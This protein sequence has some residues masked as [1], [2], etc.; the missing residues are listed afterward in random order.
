M[1]SNGSLRRELGPLVLIMLLSLWVYANAT[2]TIFHYDDIP[3]ILENPYLGSR[4]GFVDLLRTGRPLRAISF[5]IDYQVWTLDS[6]GYHFTNNLLHGFCALVAFFLVRK[7]YQDRRL[8]LLAALIFALHPVNTE[9]V[10]GVSHRKEL[11]CFLFMGLSFL[12]FGRTGKRNF[13]FGLSLL[14]YLLAL[15]SKQVALAL[16][17]LLLLSRSLFPSAVP[18]KRG[19]FWIE[20]GFFIAI[21]VLAFVFTLSDFKL[22]ARFQPADFA[23]HRYLEILATQLGA[24]PAYLRLAFFPAHL[25]LDYDVPFAH[26]FFEFRPLAGVLTLALSFLILAGLLKKKSGF[27]FGWGWFLINLLPLLNWVPANSLLAERYLY[28]PVFGISLIVAL[29]FQ[30]AD[31]ILRERLGGKAVPALTLGSANF[32]IV[33]LGLAGFG[34]TYH[35]LLWLKLTPA[36]LESGRVFVICA[37]VIGLIFSAVIFYWN[38]ARAENPGSFSADLLFFL[39]LLAAGMTIYSV[40]ATSVVYRKLIFPIPGTETHYSSWLQM[41]SQTERTSIG[42]ITARLGSKNAVSGLLA[43]FV[44]IISTQGG[45]ILVYSIHSFPLLNFFIYNLLGQALWLTLVNRLGRRPYFLKQGWGWVWLF[46]PILLAMMFTQTKARTM[47]WGWDVALWRSTVRENPHSFLGWNNLGRAYVERDKISSAMECFAV[48]HSIGPYQI[49]PILNLGNTMLKAG[50]LEA[51]EHYYRWALK[52]N[53]YSFTAQVNLGN[54]LASKREYQRAIESYLE[55]LRIKDSFEVSYN[56][57]VCFLELGDKDR[58]WFYL[59]KTLRLA[60]DHQPSRILV[61]KLKSA[62]PSRQ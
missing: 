45:P 34:Y 35:P 16:P 48:A 2:F 28:I 31:V 52:L 5:W 61:E 33:F 20:L 49:D 7:L 58:A 12:S 50:N 56:L 24:F 9:A 19:R 6:K 42:E 40:S 3:L 30:K 17:L 25:R 32:L 41:V 59:I 23:S 38:R 57:A 46:A 55:A 54:C 37:L 10:I 15:F 1:R 53:P 18:G 29:G 8:A 26:N 60:P 4:E 47:Q 44:Y 36:N 62:Q 39:A 51:A 11:L 14:F 13:W 43:R 21:P 27:G 22:F